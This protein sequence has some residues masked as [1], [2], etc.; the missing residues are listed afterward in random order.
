M[1]VKQGIEG[2]LVGDSLPVEARHFICYLVLVQ[3]RKTGNHLN[4]T[5][6]IKDQNKQTNSLHA[7]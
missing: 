2:S 6:N 4:M 5:E 1:R 7:G 3:P